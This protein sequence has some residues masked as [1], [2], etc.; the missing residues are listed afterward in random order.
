M[1]T[2]LAVQVAASVQKAR[3]DPIWFFENILNI[4]STTKELSAK[5][6]WNLD[7]WQRELI[8]A[9]ADVY[10]FKNN[11]P[12]K[13]NHDGRNKI[14]IR[15]MHG[16]GKTFGVAG[17]MHWFNYCFHGTIVCTAPKEK[18]LRTR[19]WPAFNKIKARAGKAYA[20]LMKV[21]STKIV[22]CGDESWAAHA[23]TASAPE[24]LAGYHD[25]YLL[26]VVD[27]ASGMNED[28]FPVIEGA[29]ST[30]FLVIIILIG[31]PTKNIGTFYDSHMRDK[32]ARHYYKIHV[33]LKKT[34]RVSKAWVRQMEEKY[35]KDSPVVKV[36]CKG[37]FAEMGA[38]Q[39]ISMS[40]LEEA[41]ERVFAD[42]GSL[43][44]IRV[45]VDVAD[46][47]ED[48][49]VV[50]VSRCYT[51]FKLILKQ[52][53]FSFPSGRAPILSAQ[54][55]ERMFIAS[56]G[57]KTGGNDDL[58][59]D[60]IGVGAGTAGWLIE[61]GYSVVIYKGGQ[62]SD[63][64]KLWRNR[65]VQSY[66]VA[67]NELRD[68]KVVFAEDCHTDSDWDDFCAQGCS[69]QT[70]PG[71]ERVED[72]MTKAEMVSQGIKSPDM[73]DSYIML[74]ATQ[75]PTLVSASTELT[76]GAFGIMESSTNEQW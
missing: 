53:R 17:I 5:I 67:R 48:E 11:L 36:R 49:T 43:P 54:A 37:E 3:T 25:N 57:L 52:E 7:I 29:V 1:S 13:V 72:L 61:Q 71:Q 26:F 33:D 14:T 21:D 76:T 20:S 62:T 70:K 44:K 40:W 60:S 32:V 28:M 6:N 47:G 39:L 18:Q 15:A 55:A 46:G 75:T 16:P 24:N 35:G 34:N 73:F 9:V 12:T 38:N 63:N 51:S 42:D 69:I 22:W 58:V 23:E 31:N 56:G 68:G 59:V 30:G 10:R 27:E 2:A 45:A 19:L 4:K 41:K 74:N 50:T 66:L 65:R 64:P 8:D